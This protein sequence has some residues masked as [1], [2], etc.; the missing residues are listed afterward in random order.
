MT[1][2]DNAASPSNLADLNTG[3][4]KKGLGAAAES[5]G[6]TPIPWRA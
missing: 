6:A 1:E 3:P 5:L 4:R 2:M